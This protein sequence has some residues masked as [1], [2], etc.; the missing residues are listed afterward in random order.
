MLQQLLARNPD[1]PDMLNSLGYLYA[2]HDFNLEVGETLLKK[3]LELKPGSPE[4]TD[5]YGWVLFRLGQFEQAL[6]YLQRSRADLRQP[7]GFGARRGDRPHRGKSTG[8][9]ECG[10]GRLP[11]GSAASGSPPKT[12]TCSRPSAATM[13][14]TSSS[15]LAAGCLVAALLAVGCAGREQ[16]EVDNGPALYMAGEIAVRELGQPT[17]KM[18]FKWSRGFG[19][20]GWEERIELTD[21]RGMNIAKLISEGGQVRLSAR[22]RQDRVT[23]LSELFEKFVGAPLQP[24]VLCQLAEKNRHHERAGAIPDLFD[25][26]DLKVEVRSRHLD[27]TPRELRLYRG[28]SIYAV[29]V[30]DQDVAN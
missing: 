24:R 11:S 22:N 21:R 2:D 12:S 17:R 3:A 28:D 27:E 29:L 15:I 25:Y 14:S 8:H 26:G 4:I 10:R 18:G 16:A 23:S 6:I 5:S 1:N 13:P 19:Y 7:G 20:S 9:W 30:K